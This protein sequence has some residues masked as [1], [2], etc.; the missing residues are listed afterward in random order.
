MQAHARRQ[1]EPSRGRLAVKGEQLRL[2]AEPS[3]LGLSLVEEIYVAII[4][5]ITRAD[6]PKLA[7]LETIKNHRL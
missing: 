7:L 1:T 5:V 3:L 6:D 2:P 4:K